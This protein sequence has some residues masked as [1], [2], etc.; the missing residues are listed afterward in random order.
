MDINPRWL[1]I[2]LT[3]VSGIFGA[4]G[5][6]A[7]FSYRLKIVENGVKDK[8]TIRVCDE[9]HVRTQATL[10]KLEDQG[11]RIFKKIDTVHERINELILVRGMGDK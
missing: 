6:W 8:Q 5:V 11:D 3:I 10:D 2:G 1:M 4:G 9:V 7:L